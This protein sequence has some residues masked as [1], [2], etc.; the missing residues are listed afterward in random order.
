MLMLILPS[1]GGKAESLHYSSGVQPVPKA[2]YRSDKQASALCETWTCVLP[3]A[4]TC[5][6]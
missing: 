5:Y 3:T 6:Q 1:H 4:V 2:V